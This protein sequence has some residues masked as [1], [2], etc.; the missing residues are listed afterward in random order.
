MAQ[1]QSL[2]SSQ[3]KRDITAVQSEFHKDNSC[4]CSLT[5]TAASA[6]ASLASTSS[7]KDIFKACK[8]SDVFFCKT[9]IDLWT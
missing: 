4:V 9:E 8:D 1:S 6:G 7:N 2:S 5:A 3:T